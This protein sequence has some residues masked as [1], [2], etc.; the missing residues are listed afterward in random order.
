MQCLGADP[1]PTVSHIGVFLEQPHEA[2]RKRP[3][4]SSEVPGLS[5]RQCSSLRRVMRTSSAMG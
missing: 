5:L 1:P 4:A 2:I 3:N